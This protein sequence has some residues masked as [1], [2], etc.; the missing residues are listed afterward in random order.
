VAFGFAAA[1]PARADL[2]DLKVRLT[3]DY[4]WDDN[5]TRGIEGQRL[6]DK[7]ASARLG[8]TL[9]L[10][11]GARTRVVLSAVGGGEK[12]DRYTGLDRAFLEGQAELQYRS[13]GQFGAPIYG[14]FFRQAQDWYDTTL[15]DGYRTTIGLTLRKPATDKVFLFASVG[16]N[17]RDGKSEVFDN[18]E[19]FVRGTLDYS[20]AQNHTVYLGAE[21][22]YGDSV[23][24]GL[25][26]LAFLD[27]AKA[28][29]ADDVFANRFAYKTTSHTGIVT[30][31]YNFTFLGRHALDVSYR[32]VYSRPVDQPRSSI[33]TT[34]IHYVDNQFTVSYLL[35]F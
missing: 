7:F 33:S 24:V 8:L 35:R 19:G 32:G 9:P 3:A 15:R 14:L 18:N 4:S 6:R 30:A 11:L 21:Y 34:D 13:S 29:V 28:V 22:R 23:S 2:D 17:R 1:P 25:P 27:I 12:F 26:A 10:N 16:Y 20:I 31:G 5:V